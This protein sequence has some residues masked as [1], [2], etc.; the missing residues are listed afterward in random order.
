MKKFTSLLVLCFAVCIL[1][2]FY[3]GIRGVKASGSTPPFDSNG[4]MIDN[5]VLRG[6]RDKDVFCLEIPEGVTEIAPYTL[7]YM[8]NLT[9]ISLPRSLRTVGYLAF[10]GTYGIRVIYYPGTYNEYRQIKAYS[11]ED[12]ADGYYMA[13]INTDIEYLSDVYCDGKKVS[14]LKILR[15]PD[16]VVTNTNS[17]FNITGLELEASFNDGTTENVDIQKVGYSPKKFSEDGIHPV[18]LHYGGKTTTYSMKVEIPLYVSSYIN[19]ISGKSGET[20]TMNSYASGKDIH[21]KWYRILPSEK[22]ATLLSDITTASFLLKLEQSIDGAKYYCTVTD[23]YGHVKSTNHFTVNVTDAC[24]ILKQPTKEIK[25]NS[26]DSLTLSVSAKGSNLTYQWYF[27]KRN[28][29]GWSIW[30]GHTGSTLTAFA[31]KTWDGMRVRCIVADSNGTSLTSDETLITIRDA[32]AIT[33][34]MEDIYTSTDRYTT[35]V[36]SAK[37][38]GLKYQWYYKKL[39]ASGWSVWNGRIAYWM[40]VKANSTWN[41]MQVRC[42]VTDECGEQLTTNAATVYLTDI[43]KILVEPAS[44][45]FRV[46]ETATFSVKASGRSLTYQWYYKKKGASGWTLWKGHNKAQ[47]SSVSNSTWNG[48]QVCCKVTNGDGTVLSSKPAVVTIDDII[49]ITSQPANVTAVT[50]RVTSFNV[51]ATGTDLKYQWYIRKKSASDWTLWKGHDKAQTSAAANDSWDGMKVRCRITNASGK[52][53]YSDAA[54]VTIANDTVKIISQ[55]ESISISAGHKASF[56][57]K[58]TGNNLKY[59]WY[60]KKKGASDWNIWKIYTTAEIAPP[61][62]TTWNGMQVRCAVTDAYGVTAT[63]ATASV[64]LIPAEDSDFAILTHPVNV[65]QIRGQYRLTT[66]FVEA[67]GSGLSYQWYFIKKGQKDWNIWKNNTASSVTA[68]PND[69]WEGMQVYC[70]IT[71]DR[72]EQLYS[73]I[74]KVIFN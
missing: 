39:G 2:L 51:K 43:F 73:D 21:C 46:G 14:S 18:T 36:T 56:S 65:Q 69:T 37:G 32:L 33:T 9:C 30:K 41:G 62:N 42:T 55:P 31:N 6:V 38:I 54:A 67:K 68:M 47:I 20:V 22:T 1:T 63:S 72:G 13:G 40:S 60:Y 50:G 25:L 11:T 34:P 58:A 24:R 53:M 52:T 10:E 57:V 12:G 48:M 35:F 15:T 64:T 74:A 5:G 66:F 28:A 17:Y 4:M 71:N 8:Q 23:A 29:S 19:D 61:S 26:E 3:P 44:G 27:R 70:V 45:T 49:R 7:S 16:K 59:Q